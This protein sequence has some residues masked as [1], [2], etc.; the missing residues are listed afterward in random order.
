MPIL[1]VVCRAMGDKL[2]VIG[3]TSTV[4]IGIAIAASTAMCLL[5]LLLQMLLHILLA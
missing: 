4:L 2:G 3:G 5:Y 1:A